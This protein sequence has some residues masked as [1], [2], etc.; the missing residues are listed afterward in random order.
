M[1]RIKKHK[2][3]RHIEKEEPKKSK[4]SKQMIWTIILGGTM[5]LSVFGIMFSSYNSGNE[6][7]RYGDYKFR[8]S[9]GGW[10]TEIN[11]NEAEFN[12]LPQDLEKLNLSDDVKERLLGSKVVYITFNPN[13]KSVDMFELMRFELGMKLG[14]IGGVYAMQ[15]V[16]EENENYMQPLVDCGNATSSVPVI[17][18]VE[19]NE[20]MA[21]L[22][23]DCIVVESDRYS[24]PAMKDVV[25]YTMLGIM[26]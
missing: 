23:G 22:D 25:L 15:G 1:S 13:T 18:L 6:K 24:A 16:A 11:G 26:K 5:V 7:A 21:Y 4:M 20:T 10:V 9:S 19:G 14:E 17:S 8:Q 12:Y 3:S 2:L